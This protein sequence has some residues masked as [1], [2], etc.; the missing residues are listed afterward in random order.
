[1]VRLKRRRATSNGSFSLTRIVVIKS[2]NPN[3]ADFHQREIEPFDEHHAIFPALKLIRQRG[4]ASKALD[5][6]Y[7]KGAVR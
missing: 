2:N 5:Y 7:P 4:F 1:M 6:S 3:C